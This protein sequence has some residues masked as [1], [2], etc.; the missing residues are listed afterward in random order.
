MGITKNRLDEIDLVQAIT[1][2]L[3][4]ENIYIQFDPE[5]GFI[6]LSDNSGTLEEKFWI[7]DQESL[8]ILKLIGSGKYPGK[9]G[10]DFDVK[11]HA[12]GIF[13]DIHNSGWEDNKVHVKVCKHCDSYLGIDNTNNNTQIRRDPTKKADF[14]WE[15]HHWGKN[16]PFCK[17]KLE[18]TE[19]S[20]KKVRVKFD[21]TGKIIDLQRDW[22][23]TLQIPV[24]MFPVIYNGEKFYFMY[25]DSV[26]EILLMDDIYDIENYSSQYGPFRIKL[27]KGRFKVVSE[28]EP[29]F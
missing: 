24:T 12:Y 29:M 13:T 17:K 15:D 18:M 11:E 8:Y 28:I 1:K 2:Q 3:W 23:E 22:D 16:C 27:A 5:G 10:I 20:P 21:P 14:I 9:K 26:P 7:R 6:K 25:Y 4:I 19:R